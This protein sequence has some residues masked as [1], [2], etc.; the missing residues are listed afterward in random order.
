MAVVKKRTA[1]TFTSQGITTREALKDYI[2]HKLGY[3]QLTVELSNEQLEQA[4]DDATLTWTKYADLKPRYIIG[5]L[6][7][8]E[9][10]DEDAGVDEGLDLSDYN[11]AAVHGI[12]GQDTFGMYGSDAIWGLSNCMLATGTYPFMGR[13]FG[14]NSF[15]GFTTLQTAYEFVQMARRVTAQHFDYT[16]Y[17]LTQKLV[18]YPSPLKDSRYKDTLVVFQAECVPEDDEL[19]GN[20][21]VK[22]LAVA[23]AKITLGI[24]RSKFQNVTFAGATTINAEIG[25]EGQAELADLIAK[26]KGEESATC[27]FF[28]A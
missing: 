4:I 11:V 18:L 21:Y 20:D 14:G 2:T 24:V 12:N 26:I 7:K 3:P 16:F 13:Q 8:Y 17:P 15:E 19:Y 10:A 1:V 23:F 9:E 28:Y 6:S 22:R 27:G 5:D 25:K